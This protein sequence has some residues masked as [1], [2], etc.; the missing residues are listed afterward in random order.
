M[1]YL[2]KPDFSKVTAHTFVDALGQSF[3]SLSLGTGIIITYASYV[4][5]SENLLVAG[6]GSTVSDVL[7]AILAGFAILPAVFAAGIEPGTGP[8]LLF[9]TL[10]YIFSNLALEA[11]VLSASVAIL[12][13]LAILLAALTSSISLVEVGVAYLTEAKGMK[14]GWAC[15][16]IFAVCGAF[17][18]LCSLS[19]GP[20]SGVKIFGLNLFDFA[21]NLVSNFL[22][23][24]G[25]LISVIL[26][27]WVMPKKKL[28]G[29]LTNGGSLR[30]NVKLFPVILFLLRYVAPIGILIL[31]LSTVL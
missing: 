15:V 23:V 4:S 27:G 21:D 14:R 1:E 3:F 25:G 29:E 17:G 9:D 24:L 31:V 8:T 22:M 16:L 5:K 26:A 12:F 30:V 19:F 28:F 7:F 2:L 6:V 20:L 11:P 13:F 18:C 10:P